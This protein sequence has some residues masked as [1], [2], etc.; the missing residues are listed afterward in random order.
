MKVVISN[1]VKTQ[2]ED[3][4]NYYVKTGYQNYGFKVRENVI[5][6]IY[7]LAS[8]PKLGKIDEDN[9]GKYSYRYLIEGVHRIYYRIDQNKDCIFIVFLFD[10]RQ[11]PDKL[12]VEFPE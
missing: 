2:L 7:R 11:E 9:L 10:C 6:S 12:K 4:C 1:Y 5:R 8:F 3:I